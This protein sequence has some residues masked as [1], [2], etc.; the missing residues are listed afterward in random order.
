MRDLVIRGGTVVTMDPTR[1]VV[2]GDL[3]VAD[4]A[5]AAIG[6]DDFTARGPSLDASGCLVI[7]GLIQSHIHM[8]QTL[9][10]GRADDLDLLGW[11]RQ[12]IWPDEGALDEAATRASAELACAELLLAQATRINRMDKLT[13]GELCR[14]SR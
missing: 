14:R 9:M 5:I 4:G 6:G 13:I 10:R 7:P 2:T 8:C 12:R 11:L 3:M 1:R